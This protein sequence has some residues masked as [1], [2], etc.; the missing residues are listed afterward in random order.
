MRSWRILLLA[1]LLGPVALVGRTSA[2]T[3][4]TWSIAVTYPTTGTL[5]T[6]GG[7]VEVSGTI[8]YTKPMNAPAPTLP[9]EVHVTI[10]NPGGGSGTFGQAGITGTPSA[11]PTGG[12]VPFRCSLTVPP[13]GGVV[14][15]TVEGFLV[16]GGSTVT[17]PLV[18]G[19]FLVT[20]Q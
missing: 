16:T 8:S 20:I 15:M 2:Q 3:G 1:L 17:P 5:L 7:T 11:G 9:A 10:P 14:T 6:A 4:V 19:G 18:S 13:S 12:S